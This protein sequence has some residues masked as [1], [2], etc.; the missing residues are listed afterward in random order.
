MNCIT[1]SYQQLNL[2]YNFLY[3]LF[4]DTMLF[5]DP[6]S[7]WGQKI[8]TLLFLASSEIRVLINFWSSLGCKNQS[9]DDKQYENNRYGIEIKIG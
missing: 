5:F 9:W 7:G 3:M 2:P 1:G 4:F 6:Y 8:I